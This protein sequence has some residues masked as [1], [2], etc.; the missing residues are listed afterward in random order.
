MS[1]FAQTALFETPKS[2]IGPFIDLN[3]SLTATIQ[4]QMK[5]ISTGELSSLAADNYLSHLWRIENIPRILSFSKDDSF[6][7]KHF[8][9]KGDHILIDD[10]YNITGMI[11]WE[12]AS[13]EPAALAFSTPCMFWPVADFYDGKNN[14][15]SEEVEFAT[16]FERRGRTDL[17]EIV[18][19]GRKMQ[20]FIFFNGGGASTQQEE[21]EALF[22]GLRAAM[23]GEHEGEPGSY[24]TWRAEALEHILQTILRGKSPVKNS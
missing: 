4:L 14:L 12:F 9:D 13:T 2:S 20:R 19:A 16:M 17:A 21:F 3:T 24:Q 8:D 11:D 10:E 18:R 22:Q 15:A 5:L 1:A 6:Y 7:L 23:A